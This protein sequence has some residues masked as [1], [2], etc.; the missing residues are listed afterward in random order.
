MMC[1]R[2]ANRLQKPV[3]AWGTGSPKGPDPYRS[4]QVIGADSLGDHQ[5]R[6]RDDRLIQNGRRDVAGPMILYG[7]DR[8]H[9]C[10]GDILGRNHA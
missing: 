4:V 1:L 10:P 6:M 5:R 2:S 9:G 3:M 7:L 8:R